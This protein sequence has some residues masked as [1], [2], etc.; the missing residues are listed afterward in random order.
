MYQ[1]VTRYLAGL[2]VVAIGLSLLGLLSFNWQQVFTTAAVAIIVCYLT[3]R[4][5]A[6]L[7]R[8]SANKES[9]LISA[10]ILAL[11]IG[12]GSV[13]GVWLPLVVA[14]TAAMASKYLLKWNNRHLFN[15]A[16][17]GLIVMNLLVGTGSSWWV[18]TMPL[19]IAV[20]IG[21][22][23]ICYK[24]RRIRL[25]LLFIVSYL[26]LF[27]LLNSAQLDWAT[28]KMFLQSILLDSPVIFFATI[29]LIEPATSPTGWR[30]RSVYAV[31][32]AAAILLIQRFLPAIGFSFELG[33]LAGNVFTRV[34]EKGT[35]WPMTLVKKER[36]TPNITSFFFETAPKIN[37]QPGQFLE[38]TVPHV[39]PDSRGIRRWF[40]IA[41]S[42]TESFIQLTTRFAEQSSS[43]KTALGSLKI[44]EHIWA[45][46]LEGDF[47][48]P[49]DKTKAL[50]FIAGGIGITP[51]RSMIKYLLDRGEARDITLL[52]AVKKSSDLVFLDLFEE[53]KEAFGVKIVTVVTE[54]DEKWRGVTGNVDKQILTNQIP[55]LKDAEVFVSGPEPMVEKLSEI[56][57][58]C[59]VAN[60]SI[61]QDFFPGYT[62]GD[63]EHTS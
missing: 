1:L 17:I 30:V 2:L 51:F 56:L 63:I 48:L 33:L 37:F 25:S 23:V 35:N 38:W 59:G 31:L 44:G 54:P 7:F 3:N 8:V 58:D 10:L 45:H 16:A 26:V 19:T 61:H 52:F 18:G 24:V 50:V 53:A 39:H 28:N 62:A 11:V 21:G 4:I 42:P 41:S 49:K 55:T 43:L 32:V 60:A 34:V 57:R 36:L 6:S 29:M 40:T 13:T 47:V 27:F 15:P 46:G 9:W 5:F 12:P 22:L 20:I 14:G